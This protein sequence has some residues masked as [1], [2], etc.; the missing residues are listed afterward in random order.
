MR[1]MAISIYRLSLLLAWLVCQPVVASATDRPEFT[2]VY[3][4]INDD[5]F[6]M[7]SFVAYSGRMVS[8]GSGNYGIRLYK[9]ND[10]SMTTK[11]ELRGIRMDDYADAVAVVSSTEV[12]AG[13]S[14][15]SVARPGFRFVGD[16]KF[17]AG[18]E[19]FLKNIPRPP[20]DVDCT[21]LQLQGWNCDGGQYFF[22]K[23]KEAGANQ[24]MF[25]DAQWGWSVGDFFNERIINETTTQWVPKEDVCLDVGPLDAVSE[26]AL[27]NF[28]YIFADNSGQNYIIACNVNLPPP[29]KKLSGWSAGFQKQI[30]D[31][32]FKVGSSR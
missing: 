13:Y 26:D 6:E 15:V 1:L 4:H 17:V 20:T 14:I 29:S 28:G 10:L 21:N 2:G 19:D 32:K 16:V 25:A 18:L 12:A 30:S 11:Y 23:D 7:S 24:V 22:A 8:P 9:A 5:F 31:K 3:L 27:Q